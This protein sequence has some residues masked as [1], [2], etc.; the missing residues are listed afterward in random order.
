MNIYDVVED[1][2]RS[3][4]LHAVLDVYKLSDRC[5][6]NKEI[7]QDFISEIVLI[8]L[9][10]KNPH[11]LIEMHKRDE[12]DYFILRIIKNQI[13]SKRTKFWKCYGRWER[14]RRSYD[15]SH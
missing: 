5:S 12:L 6:E 9:T 2:F 10:Y 1:L 11:K 14:N 3:G 15:I 13:Y 7:K 4:K 8:L